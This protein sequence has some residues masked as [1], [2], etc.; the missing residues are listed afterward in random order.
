MYSLYKQPPSMDEYISNVYGMESF[1]EKSQ[2]RLQI[3]LF[4]RTIDTF[5]NNCKCYKI[6]NNQQY[7][8]IIVSPV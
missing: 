5:L 4:S 6:L 8:I 1:Q 3:L 7:T 2:K